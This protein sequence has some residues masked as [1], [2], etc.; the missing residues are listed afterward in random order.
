MEFGDAR[1]RAALQRQPPR[2]GEHNGEVLA[3][4]GFGPAEIDALAAAGV[5]VAAPAAAASA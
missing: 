1:G 2:M 5:I 4:A 3:E